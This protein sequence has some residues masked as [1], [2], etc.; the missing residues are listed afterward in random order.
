M[1]KLT[2]LLQKRINPKEKLQGGVKALVERS[3]N[4]LPIFGSYILSEEEK[5][6][7][8]SL[9]D[10]F[11]KPHQVVENDFEQLVVVTQEVKAI[12]NQAALLHGE[13]IQKAQKILKSYQDGAFTA[14]LYDTYGNRQTPYNLLQY[15]E[16][17]SKA[18]SHL[19]L[20]I[21]KMPRQ[22]VYTL[23]S[24]SISFSDKKAFVEKFCG[25]TKEELL[26]KIREQFPIDPLDGRKEDLAVQFFKGIEKAH[27]FLQRKK[28]CFSKVQKKQLHS[29]IDDIKRW[30]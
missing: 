11:K 7:L 15:Y 5:L 25:E 1:K 20:I 12:T 27:L 13:R 28:V 8:K 19:K 22:A 3:Q 9:L 18:P 2:D 26:R 21:D 23:A 16:F 30:I 6:R 24:R 17:Y 14:W 29:L 10:R 4:F